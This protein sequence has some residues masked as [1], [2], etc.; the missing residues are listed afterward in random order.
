MPKGQRVRPSLRP[1]YDVSRQRKEARRE[2]RVA[3]DAKQPVMAAEVN[4][5][6]DL[7][8]VLFTGCIQ[9]LFLAKTTPVKYATNTQ[10]K[11]RNGFVQHN[12]L[13]TE[14]YGDLMV[15]QPAS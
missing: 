10:N 12:D 14:K 15:S 8:T 7:L 2:N 4:T 9:V 6:G 13:A 11:P 3:M 1:S 5:D